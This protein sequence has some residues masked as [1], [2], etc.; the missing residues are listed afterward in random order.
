M[1]SAE[2][3]I[4]NIYE[5]ENKNIFIS[6]QSMVVSSGLSLYVLYVRLYDGV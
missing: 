1:L 3:R 4:D 5:Q 6:L 2:I